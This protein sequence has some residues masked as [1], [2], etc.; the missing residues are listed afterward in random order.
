MTWTIVVMQALWATTDYSS[1]AS[2]SKDLVV[3]SRRASITGSDSTAQQRQNLVTAVPVL[4]RQGSAAKAGAAAGATA[5][6]AQP[7]RKPGQW[8]RWHAEVQAE[9]EAFCNQL[10]AVVNDEPFPEKVDVPSGGTPNGTQLQLLHH[11]QPTE[12]ADDSQ[13]FDLF[14]YTS[15]DVVSGVLA[16]RGTWEDDLVEETI[17]RLLNFAGVSN[18][19][20]VLCV[21]ADEWSQRDVMVAS[22][23]C[24]QRRLSVWIWAQSKQAAGWWGWM[25]THKTTH[26]LVSDNTDL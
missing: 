13:L 24:T 10:P 16:K 23:L 22:A 6:A 19:P 25:A 14:V 4:E 5:A 18:G 20:G 26:Y 11:L 15:S 7:G 3:D 12:W 2:R 21:V 8:G 17:D 9:Q 1:A